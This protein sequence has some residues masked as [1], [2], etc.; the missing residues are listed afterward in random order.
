MLRRLPPPIK[1]SDQQPTSATSGGFGITSKPFKAP[2]A[3]AST[4]QLAIAPRKRKAVSYRGQGGGKDD[5]DDGSDEDGKP[6]KKGKFEMGNKCY[7]EDGVL[8]DMAKW[9]NRK[10]PVFKPKEKGGVFT[11]R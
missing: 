9:C 2:S 4:R 6:A 7:G 11:K 3:L 10:F 1:G 5:D 8:G